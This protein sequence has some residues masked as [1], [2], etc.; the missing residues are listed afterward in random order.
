MASEFKENKGDSVSSS[1]NAHYTR[2]LI[3]IFVPMVALA[4]ALPL[5]WNVSQQGESQGTGSLDYVLSADQISSLADTAGY[6]ATGDEVTSI[7]LL[8]TSDGSA[9]SDTSTA[10]ETASSDSLNASTSAENLASAHIVVLNNTQKFAK[11]LE[12]DSFAQVLVGSDTQALSSYYADSGSEGIAAAIAQAGIISIDHTVEMDNQS[13]SVFLEAVNQGSNDISVDLE[14]LLS[15]IKA[16]DM[17]VRTLREAFSQAT[18]YGFSAASIVQIP[19]AQAT[20]STGD[21]YL[22]LDQ[23]QIGLEARTI[24]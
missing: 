2:V 15:G 12:I 17:S 5:L 20:D 8:V 10:S 22:K 6:E 11:L 21:S 23:A 1:E 24:K 9:T 14:Q 13:W 16:N 18:D 7:L 19:T 3:A 4:I